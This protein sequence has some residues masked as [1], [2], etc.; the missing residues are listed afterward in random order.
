MK[1]NDANNIIRS[2]NYYILKGKYDM[3]VFWKRLFY[4]II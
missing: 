2:I 4:Q 3:Y 1:S